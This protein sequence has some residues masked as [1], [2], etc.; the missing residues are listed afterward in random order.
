MTMNEENQN[1]SAL[2]PYRVLD[3]AEG[4]CMVGGKL[5]ADLGADVIKIEPP[6][7]SRSRIGPFYK[8]IRDPEKSLFWF[9]YN[10]SKRGVTLDLEK[11]EGQELFKKLL[12]SVDI[13]IESFEVGYLGRLG[14]GYDDLTRI[15]PD[16]I[17]SSISPFG[18]TGPK[19]DFKG[20]DLTAWASGGF[21]YTCGDEDRAP[22]WI[23]FPQATLIAGV[24]A[25][26]GAMCA[27][28]YRI[29]SGEGQHVDVSMQECAMAPLWNFLQLW[30]VNKDNITRH[31][32]KIYIGATG[33]CQT[34]CYPCREGYVLVL[35]Q[36]GN[37]PLVG[38]TKRLV[39]WMDEEGMAE[40]WLKEVDFVA[41]YNASALT[42]E[43][44]EK[45]EAAVARFT[46][47]KTKAEL[48]EEGGI[49]RRIL[50]APVSTIE[51][52]ARNPQLQFRDYWV[53]VPHPELGETLTYCGPQFKLTETPLS[54]RRPAPL[55]GQHNR[56][57]YG[58]E[59]GLSTR[60]IESLKLAGVI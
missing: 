37:E 29:A 2:G 1:G 53:K 10:T 4:G 55:I 39:E 11:P 14:L 56:D 5:F 36:G 47:T 32:G 51:D 13:I 23:S 48:F 34:V 40:D 33:V 30:D 24:E 58:G 15:K 26:T 50:L 42:A 25:A 20:S 3:L 45:V 16:I 19:A 43:L 59:L 18:Q 28:W 52:V 21:L 38:S 12:P 8:D 60:E 27:L 44:A 31:G 17:V 6:G 9:A 22:S 41:D 35:V 54:Y 7:G 49:K 46:A 57:I